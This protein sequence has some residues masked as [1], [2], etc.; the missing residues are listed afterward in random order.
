[1]RA[2]GFFAVFAG[3]KKKNKVLLDLSG[4]LVTLG[5]DRCWVVVDAAVLLTRKPVPSPSLFEIVTVH[6]RPQPTFYVTHMYI[7]MY[8]C[9][10]YA[11]RCSA[12]ATRREDQNPALPP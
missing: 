9:P 1:M 6:N 11:L 3:G 2:N 4:V 7:Y 12:L 8:V 10:L 5:F